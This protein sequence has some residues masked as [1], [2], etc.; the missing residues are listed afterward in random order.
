MMHI[1]Q[2]QI[3]PL[4]GLMVNNLIKAV[5]H[6]PSPWVAVDRKEYQDSGIE[7]G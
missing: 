6:M 7:D 1:H 5:E 2:V 4:F 3:I